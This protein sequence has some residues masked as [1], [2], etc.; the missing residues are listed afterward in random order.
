MRALALLTLSLGLL[1]GCSSTNY[2]RSGRSYPA[3][4]RVGGSG[5]Q[6]RYVVCHKGKDTKTLPQSAVRGHLN[7]GDRFGACRSDRRDDRR[8]DRRGNGNG[9][10][11]GNGRN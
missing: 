9:R 2:D 5:S 6:A 4:A 8:D 10:G 3:S 11:R 1:A 7:H